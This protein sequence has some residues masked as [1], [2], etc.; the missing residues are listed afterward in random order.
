[1]VV[2]DRPVRSQGEAEDLARS[3]CDDIGSDFLQADGLCYGI[4]ALKPGVMVAIG[5][6][7][8]R[9]SGSYYVTSTTH[10]YTPAEGYT[11]LFAVSGK[12]ASTLLSLMEEDDLSRRAPLGGNI[13]VGVVTDNRDPQ[14]MGRVKVMYPWLTE[15]YTSFWARTSSQMAGKGRGMFNLPEIDDE[16]L[17]AFEHGD[18]SRPYVI[19]QLWNGEDR[20]PSVSG[21]SVLGPSSEVNRRGFYSR[22]G[23]QLNFDDTGGQ[24]D[25][26][27]RTAGGHVLTI[28]D[29]GKKVAITTTGGQKLIMDDAGSRITVL[30]NAGD[31]LTM[32]QG[33]VNL[34]AMQAINLAAPNINIS[35]AENLNMI[36]GTMTNVSAGVYLGLQGTVVTNMS[37]AAVKINGGIVRVDG[38][39]V[40]INSP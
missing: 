37:S 21:N 39:K 3:L 28:D 12:R 11:T 30:D 40:D 7:G 10:T 18:V 23:H 20:L 22:I 4:P 34:I 38:A 9:F 5:N 26:T 32:S 2:V 1:M 31:M 15:E 13:V 6:I 14:G 24:G 16:V 29:A 27:L 17:V 8:K 35:A 36:G 25:I 19:G 33:K